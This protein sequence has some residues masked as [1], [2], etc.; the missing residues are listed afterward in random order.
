PSPSTR[1]FDWAAAGLKPPTQPAGT[2]K[3]GT[4]LAGSNS[5]SQ[6]KCACCET[7]RSSAIAV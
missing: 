5:A 1:S 3:C 7:P 2:W 4:C 6:D